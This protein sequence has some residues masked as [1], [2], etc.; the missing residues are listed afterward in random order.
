MIDQARINQAVALLVDA[1]HPGRIVLFGS[2]A[3]GDAREDSDLNF[4]VIQAHVENRA[5]EVVRLRRVL[6]S[7]RIAVDIVVYSS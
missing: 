1:A 5:G 4:L 3:R 6:R 7:L 2:H